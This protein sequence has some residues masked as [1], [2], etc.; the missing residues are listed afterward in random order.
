MIVVFMGV[1]P[2]PFPA[3]QLQHLREWMMWHRSVAGYDEA[4][5]RSSRASHPA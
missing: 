2:C 1:Y 5:S 4:R 3:F